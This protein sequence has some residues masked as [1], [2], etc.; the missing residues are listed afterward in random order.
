MLFTK[1]IVAALLCITSICSCSSQQDVNTFTV[2]GEIKN[3]PDQPLY[4]EELFF[5]NNNPQVI[6]TGALKGGKFTVTGIAQQQGLYRIRLA[7][8]N[9]GFIFINDKPAIRFTADLKDMGIKNTSFN[10]PANT[11]LKNYI[12]T[13]DSIGAEYMAASN[14][15]KALSTIKGGDSDSLIAVGK[16]EMQAAS[17][18]HKAYIIKFIDT[19]TN[20]VMALFALGNASSFDPSDIE[21]QVMGLT[22][23]FPGHNAIA[24][25]TAQ[26]AEI[27]KQQN[28]KEQSAK[29]QPGSI[30]PDI[31]MPDTTD[32][33][34]SLSSLKGK[35]VLVDFWASWCGP[36]RAEN[37][38][39]VKA[40]NAFKDKNFTVLGV[41]LDKDKAAWLQAI[42][43]DGLSWQHISDL[44]KWSSPVVPLYG[45]EGIPYNVLVDPQGKVIATGL[46]EAALLAKLGEVIK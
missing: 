39:V 3:A 5:S 15:I 13:L 7:D 4:L 44:K 46:R 45:I 38:N 22:S 2:T 36:C 43:E 27:R 35:Y 21:K 1:K 40:Y 41:S 32:K 11:T 33:P 12:F 34:F 20:P 17:N 26:F 25:I 37:P 31:T 18:S 16:T 23:R 29:I 28:A 42:K 9:T 6:D 10:S 24:T 14:R 30:A 19:T 8:G